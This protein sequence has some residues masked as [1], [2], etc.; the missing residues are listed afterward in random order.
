M[1]LHAAAWLQAASRHGV[2]TSRR[3]IYRWEGEPGRLT[4]RRLLRRR[5]GSAPTALLVEA[6]LRDKERRFVRLS[7]RL[8]VDSAW[9]ALLTCLTPRIRLA[10][11]TGTSRD[12]VRRIIPASI[13]RA[14]TAMITS[15]SVAHGKPDPEPY[16]TALAK[17]RVR[18]QQAIV[19]ENARYGVRSARRARVGLIIALTGSLPARE[20]RSAGADAIVHN[21]D[22]LTRLLERLIAPAGA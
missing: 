17:L 19:V 22:Q 6:L 20:L 3:E 1:P 15:E 4:A 7:R 13:R 2:R 9:R 16:R 8:R 10:L 11:V 14:F 21:C 5:K 18:P 12:E